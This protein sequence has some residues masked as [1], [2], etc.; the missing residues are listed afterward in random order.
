MK[1]SLIVVCMACLIALTTYGCNESSG[2]GG[3]SSS[4]RVDAPAEKQIKNFNQTTRKNQRTTGGPPSG[5][6][7]P[8]LNGQSVD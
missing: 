1:K 6:T 2:G 7:I 8:G 3:S 5:R 4:H